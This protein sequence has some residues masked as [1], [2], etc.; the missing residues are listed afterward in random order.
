M[1]RILLAV[2]GL[3]P[4]V[5][6]ETF[7]ALHQQGRTPDAIR[8]LTTREGKSVIHANLLSLADGHYYRLLKDYEIAAES[9]DFSARHNRLP[10]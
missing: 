6:T 1:K 3:N 8:I 7:Y 10:P 5:I 4:Q 2:A 9:I